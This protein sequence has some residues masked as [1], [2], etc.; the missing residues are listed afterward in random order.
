MSHATH[1]P[2]TV[3]DGDDHDHAHHPHHHHHQA[4]AHVVH[5]V[6]DTPCCGP[7]ITGILWGVRRSV[8]SCSPPHSPDP[9]H[10][11]CGSHLPLAR[12]RRPL[13]PLLRPGDHL[14]LHRLCPRRC[15]L[16]YVPPCPVVPRSPHS[17]WHPCPLAPHRQGRQAVPPR[18]HD[19][20]RQ[21][22][23]QRPPPNRYPSSP[24]RRDLTFS[25]ISS[26]RYPRHPRRHPAAWLG[27]RRHDHLLRLR[28]LRRLH[29]CHHCRA[30]HPCL[31]SAAATDL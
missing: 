21:V 2:L 27:G 3:G 1:V 25:T 15:A 8:S 26:D 13:W 31:P 20:R 24:A 4:P 28:Y 19:L 7:L 6:H 22:R 14:D 12:V 16:W 5:H 11:G 23:S 9:S 29:Q 30:D 18:H 10:T 17:V